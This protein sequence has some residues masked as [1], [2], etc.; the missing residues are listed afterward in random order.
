MGRRSAECVSESPFI[1]TDQ[2]GLAAAQRRGPQ[3]AARTEHGL[4]ER[5]F[6]RWI[7]GHVEDDHPLA[8]GHHHFARPPGQVQ[9]FGGPEAVLLGVDDFF[10]PDLLVRKEPLRF[11]T[12]GSAFAVIVPVDAF[13]HDDYSLGQP[14]CQEQDDST[15]RTRINLV[16]HRPEAVAAGIR[17]ESGG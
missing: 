7:P 10:D 11:T 5:L 1:E 4:E 12:G 13:G 15:G 14:T 9:G 3:I 2:Q 16:R 17:T 8:F 6:V